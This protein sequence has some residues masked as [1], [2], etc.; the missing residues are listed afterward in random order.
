MQNTDEKISINAY[1]KINL[2]LDVTG[3][4][5]DGYHLVRMVMQTIGLHDIVTVSRAEDGFTMRLT[6]SDVELPVDETNLCIKAANR[7]REAFPQIKGACIELDKRIPIAAGLAGGSTDAAA[8]IVALND[9]YDLGQPIDRLCEIGAMVGADVPFCIT[10]GTYL[11]EGIGE[12][13]TP[14]APMPQ[15]YVLIAKPPVGVSTPWCYKTLDSLTDYAHPDIDGLVGAIKSGRI[16]EI[17][18][19]MANVLELAT[20]PTHPEIDEIKRIMRDAGAIFSMMSGSGPT[21]FG[22]FDDIETMN[23]AAEAVRGSQLAADV[24]CTEIYNKRRV[25]G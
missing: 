10:Q 22:L 21:V 1:A 13:L 17:T 4:R 19:C 8:V 25:A 23:E 5:E 9:I 15:L 24:I 12:I 16:E 20:I 3:R 14:I 2:G 18:A 6:D 7:M 11:S